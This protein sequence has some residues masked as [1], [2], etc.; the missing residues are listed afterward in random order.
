[1]SEKAVAIFNRCHSGEDRTRAPSTVFSPFMDGTR[2]Q[3][4]S[5]GVKHK[6]YAIEKVEYPS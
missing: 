1:M 4:F 2:V 5:G 6:H 3:W